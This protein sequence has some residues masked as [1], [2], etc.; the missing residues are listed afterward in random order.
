MSG[1]KKPK[2]VGFDTSIFIYYYLADTTFGPS[3]K[4][5]IAHLYDTSWQGVISTI[6][7]AELLAKDLPENVIK[8]LKKDFLSLPELKLITFDYE[9]ALTSAQIR[10]QYGFRLPDAIHLATAYH[11]QA[12]MFITNDKAL[13]RFNEIPVVLLSKIK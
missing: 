3:A 9:I 5:C 4:K 10:R 8:E 1:T 7:L 13:G 11:Q 12:D 6:T 2:R